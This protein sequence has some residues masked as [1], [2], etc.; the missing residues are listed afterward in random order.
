MDSGAK[1]FL[2]VKLCDEIIHTGLVL[3]FDVIVVLLF[4]HPY[5]P[6]DS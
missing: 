4:V 3:I 2:N 1:E 6:I 5:Y